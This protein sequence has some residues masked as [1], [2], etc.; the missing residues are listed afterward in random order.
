MP[1][2]AAGRAVK[3]SYQALLMVEVIVIGVVVVQF[4]QAGAVPRTE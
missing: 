1:E 3:Q 4:V 2:V